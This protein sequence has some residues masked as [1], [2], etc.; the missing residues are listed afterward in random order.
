MEEDTCGLVKCDACDYFCDPN[1]ED[2]HDPTCPVKKVGVQVTPSV[3]D[4][5]RLFLLS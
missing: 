1:R 5:E 2:H 3:A 4:L